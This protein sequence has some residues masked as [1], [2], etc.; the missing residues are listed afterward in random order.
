[1]SAVDLAGAAVLVLN[2]GSSTLKASV[3]PVD[4]ETPLAAV[5]VDWP[6][7][8][9]A[10]APAALGAALERVGVGEWSLLGVG[11][12]IVHG[13]PDL[14]A[15]RRLDEPTM[16]T[17]RGLLALAPLHLPPALAVIDAARARLPDVPHVGCFDTAYHATLPETAVRYP[18]PDRWVREWG[19][20]R[21]GFHG[22][23]VEWAIERAATLLQ[24][25]ID[26]LR[27]VVAHLGAGSSVTAVDGGRSVHTS[28][29]YTPLDGLMMATRSGSIDPG[30]LLA[31]LREGRLDADG[32][33]DD[34]QHRSGLLGVGGSADMRGLLDRAAA[35]DDRARLAI[36][37]FVDGGAAG[38]AAA[39]TR[40]PALDAVVF[41]GG[42][43]EHASTVRA[44]I[45]GRLA[46]LGMRPLEATDERAL[47]GDDD[48]RL[49]APDVTPAVLRVRARE[50]LVIARAVER[51]SG[52]R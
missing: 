13:G 32:L 12:R 43:G 44:A 11:H 25:P 27:L 3:I 38:I 8:T 45:V 42:I 14:T 24:R 18:V 46:V 19:I 49:S 34:L 51:L 16:A 9:Q 29:G 15:P 21:Y 23:S 50:D 4:A 39:A 2:A 30:I 6:G 1:V 31:L 20:R 22:L 48:G 40:L 52:P 17:L 28:M 47:A 41:T 5:T 26:G 10:T 36:D 37:L 33:A 7:A 35:G